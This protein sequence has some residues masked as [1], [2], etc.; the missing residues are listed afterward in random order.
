VKN[1]EGVLLGGD[2]MGLPGTGLDYRL[3]H[4]LL[5]THTST[6]TIVRKHSDPPGPGADGQTKRQKTISSPSSPGP[7]FLPLLQ[8]LL[9][10]SMQ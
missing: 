8:Y 2:L 5:S 7:L 9:K 1:G 4:S 3:R 6:H 10:G